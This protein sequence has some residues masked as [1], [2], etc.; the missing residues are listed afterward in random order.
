MSERL[1]NNPPLSEEIMEEIR[2]QNLDPEI[3]GR[4]IN[5]YGE[6]YEVNVEL[7]EKFPN[8]YFLSNIYDDAIIGVNL[9]TE[10]IIYD[11]DWVG[12]NHVH[13]IEGSS[14]DLGDRL[15]CGGIVTNW[16]KNLTHEELEG[17]VPP[18]VILPDENLEHW[19]HVRG[20]VGYPPEND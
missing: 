15:E 9:L 13:H 6:T 4:D 12:M 8:S 20:Y 16:M 1:K 17:K 11:L 3:R 2:E 10:S 18:T 19:N 14:S 7:R 5:A